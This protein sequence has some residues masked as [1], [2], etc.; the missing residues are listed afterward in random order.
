MSQLLFS[1][2]ENPKLYTKKVNE[3]Y[4]QIKHAILSKRGKEEK[5]KW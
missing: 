2:L 4:T 5:G 1:I 3:N